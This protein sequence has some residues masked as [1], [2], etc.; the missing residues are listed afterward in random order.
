MMDRSTIRPTSPD[1][2]RRDHQHGE[3]DINA[4][5]LS[6]AMRGVAAQHHEL[7]V[8]QIDHPHHPEHDRQPGA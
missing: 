4:R 8:R 7:A 6:Q 5:L 1:Y 3:I 2:H